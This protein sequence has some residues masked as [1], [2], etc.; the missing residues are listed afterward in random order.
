MRQILPEDI[1]EKI[2]SPSRIHELLE[3]TIRLKD[4]ITDFEVF[5]KLR[6]I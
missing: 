2:F 5:G 6:F 4:D 3:M 1:M